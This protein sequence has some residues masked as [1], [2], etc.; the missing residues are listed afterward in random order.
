MNLDKFN[1]LLEGGKALGTDRINKEDVKPTIAKF[2][3]QVLKPLG[4]SEFSILG[5]AGKKPTSGDI[6]LGVETDKSLED[7]SAEL[8]KLGI[9]HRV[10]KGFSEISTKFPISS[11]KGDVQID[12]M[13]GKRAWQ[14]F[15]YYSP[16]EG[17]S[18]YSGAHRN[19]LLAGIVRYARSLM[20]KKNKDW[21]LALDK[22]ISTKIRGM[23]KNKKGVEQ[24]KVI[25]KYFVTNNPESFIK[26][27]N[28]ATGADWTINDLNQPFE[29]IWIKAKKVLPS[30][31]LDK[32][33]AYITSG[34]ETKKVEVPVMEFI[35]KMR[36]EL[37][38]EMALK[39]IRVKG[40]EVET[41]NEAVKDHLRELF[42]PMWVKAEKSEQ[43][44]IPAIG[45]RVPF[46]LEDKSP[47]AVQNWLLN[48]VVG[49]FPEFDLRVDAIEKDKRDI[50]SK[51]S[52]YWTY[53]ISNDAGVEI[54]IVGQN[55]ETIEIK[56]KDGAETIKST[57]TSGALVPNKLVKE[58]TE[59]AINDLFEIIK[60]KINQKE[61]SSAVKQYIIE[62]ARV[63]AYD[64][65]KEI[66]DT[67]I[68]LDK[69]DILKK[70]RPEISKNDW[71]EINKN[72]GE[73]MGAFVKA[74]E[75]DSF[76]AFSKAGKAL[77]D[78]N[79][80]EKR[81]SAKWEKGA[82]PAITSITDDSE[83]I[84]AAKKLKFKPNGL[85]DIF[86]VYLDYSSSKDNT[87]IRYLRLAEKFIPD[88]I[89]KLKTSLGIPN[90]TFNKPGLKEIAKKLDSW[91]EDGT[92]KRRLDDFYSKDKGI[93]RR[94]RDIKLYGSRGDAAS[95]YGF[96]VSPIAAKVTSI[97]NLPD[98]ELNIE[99]GF[100]SLINK[101]KNI[102]QV[103]LMN[104][105]PD[106]IRFDT[107]RLN[108][109]RIRIEFVPGG[110]STQPNYQ[111]LRFR[112]HAPDKF[113]PKVGS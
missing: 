77:V 33:R 61:W 12:L 31:V 102:F 28:K 30:T 18:K 8:D 9:E 112:I 107:I 34:A 5:S 84:E 10:F 73:I 94:A 98:D 63:C 29:K 81:Y 90:L 101:N 45:W 100:K 60:G 36:G 103:I 3:T 75:N 19:L 21:A 13:I 38:T 47:K 97:F 92:L 1:E 113:E 95:K 96:V 74:R 2:K 65:Y 87:A 110:T 83:M 76:V 82:A 48:T 70:L 23:I 39:R 93:G 35:N 24:E 11:G 40:K 85:L 99:K 16:E 64:D 108:D 57:I 56:S 26:L 89:K 17:E 80:T 106:L 7:L 71:A 55:P 20:G 68:T 79:I 44:E 54:Y 51:S 86:N 91:K 104:E 53:R 32:I 43:K 69:T 15:A 14:E 49:K 66:G 72:F 78:Y 41:Q 58:E 22:G 37:L 105:D 59:Y 25:G 42:K 67:T 4:I 46:D 109:K 88:D 50:G 52:K 6:D 62:I 111:N 27:I